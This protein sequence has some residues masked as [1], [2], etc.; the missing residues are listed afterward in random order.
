MMN[1][2]KLAR[3]RFQVRRRGTVLLF[4]LYPT[5]YESD[6]TNQRAPCKLDLVHSVSPTD[7]IALKHKQS[8]ELIEQGS[9]SSYY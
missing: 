7:W 6:W 3:V 8:T 2:P 5:R 9:M 4:T 1:A